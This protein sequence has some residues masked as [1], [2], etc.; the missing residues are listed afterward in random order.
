MHFRAERRESFDRSSVMSLLLVKGCAEER[1]AEQE[2]YSALASRIA[3]TEALQASDQHADL[4]PAGVADG[5]IHQVARA[6]ELQ[7]I[8]IAAQGRRQPPSV[9][10]P[11]E[12]V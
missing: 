5:A 4:A 1:L 2:F 11:R 6:P 3:R 10:G 8:A 9:P 12:H 7:M